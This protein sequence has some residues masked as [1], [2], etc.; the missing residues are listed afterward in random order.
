MT[1]PT[2]IKALEELEAVL[3]IDRKGRSSYGLSVIE[4]AAAAYLQLLKGEHETLVI[5]PRKATD[6]M[7]AEGALVF[8]LGTHQNPWTTEGIYEA[9]IQASQEVG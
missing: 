8:A 9:M 3:N 1:P 5:V 6:D 7:V 2:E 4:K